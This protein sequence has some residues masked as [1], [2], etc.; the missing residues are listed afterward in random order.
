MR[1]HPTIHNFIHPHW[2]ISKPL[3]EPDEGPQLVAWME[4]NKG[5]VLLDKPGSGYWEMWALL[6]K[7]PGSYHRRLVLAQHHELKRQFHVRGLHFQGKVTF[8]PGDYGSL[9]L[10]MTVNGFEEALRWGDNMH[11]L[12]LQL[13]A[14]YTPREIAHFKQGFRGK[15]ALLDMPC[16]VGSF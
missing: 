4:Q 10:G 9:I 14:D 8:V 1:L 13:A 12:F 16:S 2:G 6:H 3:F 11:Y 15:A 5:F 7:I